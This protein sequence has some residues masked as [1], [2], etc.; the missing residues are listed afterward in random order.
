MF[1][2]GTKSALKPKDRYDFS[3]VGNSF[4]GFLSELLVFLQKNWQMSD[5]L[6]KISNLLIC[7]F[8]VSHVSEYLTVAHFW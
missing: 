2:D 4:I 6:K 8:L 3:R 5:S 1:L 7:S